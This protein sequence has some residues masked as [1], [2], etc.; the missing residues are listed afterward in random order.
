MKKTFLKSLLLFLLIHPLAQ[1][2][3][4]LLQDQIWRG[5]IARTGEYTSTGPVKEPQLKWK[6]KTGGLVRSSPVIVDGT[7]YIG[8]D[9]KNFYALDLASGKEKWKFSAGAPVRSSPAVCSGKVFFI[10]AKGVFALNAETGE[11][12]WSMPGMFSDDS[13]L[14]LQGE[15]ITDRDGKKLEGILFYGLPLKN[16]IGVDIADGRE[17]WRYR[18]GGSTGKG[19]SS[20]L[21]HRGLLTFFRGSQA[22][23]LVDV[24]TERRYYE[25]DGG[26]D[27]AIFTPAARGGICFSY[28]NG[29]VAF[30]M[31]EYG[32]GNTKKGSKSKMK[33]RFQQAGEKLWDNQ[34][35]GISSIS[36]DDKA[37]YFG[38]VDKHV[39]ALDSNTGTLLWKT[40]TGGP[41]SSSPALGSG[42]L[43]FVGGQDKMIYGIN[44]KDGAIA[45]KFA[46]GGPVYSSPAP[47][48]NAVV[49]GS[50][51][52]YVYALE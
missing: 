41:V 25:I 42:E 12:V 15:T 11:K 21:M 37:V 2:D 32:K 24:L 38:Q 18:D 36:V 39:Y 40:I 52:G 9:D 5:N 6:F 14:V 17:V 7:V 28:I 27:N 8:S 20:I 46:T 31:I 1:A 45:W 19:G 47:S 16:V 23:V 48:G 51:D 3:S 44:K 33:W 26:I 43:L 10:N 13:P 22:T 30:D 49:V 35:P 50:D 34:H 4:P 29:I